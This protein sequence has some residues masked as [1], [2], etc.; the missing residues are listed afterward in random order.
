MDLI[1]RHLNNDI[2]VQQPHCSAGRSAMHDRLLVVKLR[3]L[4]FRSATGRV[5]YLMVRV[6]SALAVTQFKDI[7]L[8]DGFFLQVYRF[9]AEWLG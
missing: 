3:K 2:R 5:D 7:H 1:A 8:W 4:T 9:G 6:L